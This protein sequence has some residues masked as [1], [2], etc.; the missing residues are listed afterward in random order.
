MDQRQI[1]EILS[2]HGLWLAKRAGGERADFSGVNLQEAFLMG[3][4]LERANLRR[5]NFRGAYLKGANL[6]GANFERANLKET[7]LEKANLRGAD[8]READLW[9][10]NLG[11]ATLRGA[12]LEGADLIGAILEDAD[13]V[14]FQGGRHTAY[15]TLN[16]YIKIGCYHHTT[17]FWLENYEKFGEDYKYSPTEIK[18]YGQF[19]K[20]CK[21]M[22]ETK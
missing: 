16:G 2:K 11:G 13:I 12:Y 8:L 5:A 18:A 20:L 22:E 4:T 1:D 9:G 19:I 10:A 17:K 3:A 15:C 6:M 7:T 21:E 14:S